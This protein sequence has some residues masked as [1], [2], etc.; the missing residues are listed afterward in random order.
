MEKK[1]AHDDIKERAGRDFEALIDE[2]KVLS[3]EEVVDLIDLE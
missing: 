1:T 2:A 3:G